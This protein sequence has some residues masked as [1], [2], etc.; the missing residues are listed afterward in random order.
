MFGDKELFLDKF[1]TCARARPKGSQ[2][3]PS[4]FYEKEHTKPLF[5]KNDI[6]T[7]HNIYNIQCFMEIF[8]ILKLRT[9]ISLYSKFSRSR[10]STNE[11]LL[12]TPAPSHNFMY[13]S[14][15]LWNSLK[16][17][18]KIEDLAVNIASVKNALKT[19]ILTNQKQNS[20]TDWDNYNFIIS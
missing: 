16:K 1:K 15:Y 6:L 4:S 14:S 20:K 17:K 10:R 5:V 9:P 2:K 13:K 18:L 19:L 8:K 3:L 7:V 11:T 12:I